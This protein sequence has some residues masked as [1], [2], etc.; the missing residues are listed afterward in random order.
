MPAGSAKTK[1]S[2]SGEG[3]SKKEA[4][5]NSKDITEKDID[6]FQ[7]SF[8]KFEQGKIFVDIYQVRQDLSWSK[9]K[10]DSV[11]A[12]LRKE[13]RI[14]LYAGDTS[15]MTHEQIADDYVDK[16]GFHMGSMTWDK[17]TRTGK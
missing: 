3:A 15:T 8:D 14:H 10:F 2:A 7:S 11:L 13:G 5:R 1:S 4:Q 12:H 17:K 9:E 6:N 16:N